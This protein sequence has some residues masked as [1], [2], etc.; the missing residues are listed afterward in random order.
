[1]ATPRQAQDVDA[2]LRSLAPRAANLAETLALGRPAMPQKWDY[3][4]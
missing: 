1:M 4:K 3:G 2:A